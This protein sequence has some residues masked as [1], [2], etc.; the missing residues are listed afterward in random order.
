MRE[1]HP[2]R[3]AVP[4]SVPTRAGSLL[5]RPI[6]VIRAIPPAFLQCRLHHLVPVL[7]HRHRQCVLSSLLHPIPARVP[8]PLDSE[9]MRIRIRI[10]T[11]I[12]LSNISPK[13]SRVGVDAVAVH[14]LEEGRSRFL[15][16][17]W[18]EHYAYAA[19][20][21]RILDTTTIHYPRYHQLRAAAF[22]RP[23]SLEAST[24]I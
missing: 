2:L 22:F 6:F 11:Q 23:S 10:Q 19:R 16:T 8:S 4:R 9:P 12:A 7:R 21:P 18:H 15:A 24:Q 20:L 17:A 13:C 3:A 5:L 1:A 14:Y